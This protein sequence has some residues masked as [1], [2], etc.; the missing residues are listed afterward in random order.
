[1]SETI[2]HVAFYRELR[3]VLDTLSS[4]KQE[5]GEPDGGVR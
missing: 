1:M 4:E 5:H 2:K 3:R